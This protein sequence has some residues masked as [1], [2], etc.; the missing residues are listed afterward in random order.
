MHWTDFTD[1]ACAKEFAYPVDLQQHPSNALRNVGVIR[2]VRLV[3]A[4]R[5]DARNLVPDFV[6]A[7]LTIQFV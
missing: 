3:M 4:E 1:I 2:A 7:N 6:N 5:N